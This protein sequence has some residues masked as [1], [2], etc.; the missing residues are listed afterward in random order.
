MYKNLLLFLFYFISFVGFRTNK[1]ILSR[2]T[3]NTLT[4]EGYLNGNDKH[5]HGRRFI[6]HNCTSIKKNTVI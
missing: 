3:K 5:S 6:W 4:R 1:Y 2:E